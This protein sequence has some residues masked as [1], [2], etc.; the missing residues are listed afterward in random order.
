MSMS[1]NRNGPLLILAGLLTL[2]A[3][4]DDINLFRLVMPS[5]FTHSP[6][7]SF[8]LDDENTDFIKPPESPASQNQLIGPPLP[9]CSSAE[10]FQ[11]I[12]SP[13][14]SSLAPSDSTHY[15]LSGD[16]A[17]TPLRC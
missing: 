3:S 9:S 11:Q 13:L 1:R 10:T 16:S 15:Q 8:P 5:A 12:R 17:M 4:G 6:N 2:T 14:S 7:G